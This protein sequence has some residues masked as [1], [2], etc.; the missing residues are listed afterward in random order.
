MKGPSLTGANPRTLAGLF[1]IVVG[2]PAIALVWLSTQLLMQDR[3]LAMQRETERRQS[4]LQLAARELEKSLASAVRHLPQ[5]TARFAISASGISVEPKDAMLWF[6]VAAALPASDEVT[7][8]EAERAEFSGNT[9]AALIAYQRASKGENPMSMQAGGL[10]RAARV[11]WREGRWQEA[12][13]NYDQLAGIRNFG[14]EGLPADFV[15]RRARCDVLRDAR[16]Q[17]ELRVEAEALR[18]DVLANRW[19]LDRAAWEQAS[20]QIA[21]WTGQAMDVPQSRRTMSELGEWLW[22]HRT[23]RK[24]ATVVMNG[25]PVTLVWASDVV[26]AIPAKVVEQWLG[27]IALSTNVVSLYTETGQAG[28]KPAMGASGLKALPA[29]TGLPWTLM[30]SANPS[31]VANPEWEARR[32][33]LSFGLGAVVLLLAGAGYLLWRVVGKEL[34]IARL[35]TDFVAAVSHEFRTPLASMR[36]V[37]ELLKEDDELPKE[38]RGAFYESLGRNTERLH[39]LVE[40]LL[41]FARMEG[42][43]KPFELR[44]VDAGELTAEVVREFRTEAEP[45][46]YRVD[47]AVESDTAFP[48]QADPGSLANALWNLLD[49]AVKY[50]PGKHSIHVRVGRSNCGVE[51]AVEDEG[52]GIPVN[53]QKEVFRKFVRGAESKR[54]GIKG[55]GLGLAMVSHIVGAHGGVIELASKEGNG[56]TFRI[57]LPE[58]R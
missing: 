44:P 10:L 28:A 51:I 34:A 55:T 24:D 25:E 37:T 47:L 21:A 50:S 27:R 58:M 9:S 2:L 7:F 23:S 8:A 17:R 1:L 53:E 38:R 29:E 22:L 11:H 57:V 41:D 42:G 6:P 5:G 56:S 49:N 16:R 35:Q 26:T 48:V 4:D 15:A 32:R 13:Q 45:R 20:G 19:T 52:I 12:L 3:S 14:I 46:G 31:S 36:H 43:R 30:A 18:S 33:L 39:R 54:L 40:S